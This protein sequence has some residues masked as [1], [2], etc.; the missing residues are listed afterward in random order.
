[1]DRKTVLASSLLF[2][3]SFGLSGCIAPGGEYPASQPEYPPQSQTY[4]QQTYGQQAYGQDEDYEITA[5]EP[6]P[7]LPYYEQPRCPGPGYIWTPGYWSY[8]GD[9][10]YYWVPGTWAQPPQQDVYWTP[11]FWAWSGN[12]YVFRTGYWG[13]RVGYYGGVN[14]GHG[15]DGRGYEGGRWDN[16]QF[17]YNTAVNNVDVTRIH[18]TYNTTVINNNVT[19]NNISYNGGPGGTRAQPTDEQRAAARERHFRPTSEQ[20]DHQHA[21]RSDRDLYMSRNQGRPAIAAT[22]RPGAWNAREAVPA[23]EPAQR[24]DD[25]RAWQ[26][27]QQQQEQQQ[28]QQQQQQQEQGRRRQQQTDQQEQQRRS[29]QAQQMEQ[30]RMRTE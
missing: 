13:P 22:P 11:G 8:N 24:D 14:Y 6:P 20:I 28:Q 7:P 5:N 16:G 27:Q 17:R 15:Y 4:G 3:L 12:A 30:Q 25:R 1:M 10:G 23:R 18:N 9:G 29:E 26:Q 21:A 2:S 19:V